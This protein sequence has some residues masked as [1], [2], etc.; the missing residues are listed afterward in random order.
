MKELL[1]F[2]MSRGIRVR[3]GLAVGFGE[4]ELEYARRTAG[5]VWA[6]AKGEGEFP[7]ESD[8]FDLVVLSVPAVSYTSVRE[9][10][11]VLVKG[12]NLVFSVPEKN[13]AQ[14]GLTPPEIY[15]VVREG[16]DIVELKKPGFWQLRR[17]GRVFKVCACKKA[18]REHHDFIREG[19]LP[20]TPFRSRT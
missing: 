12:G 7:Y 3:A 6:A 8:Q 14:E 16:F 19:S 11:R 5:G 13:G 1:E 4:E 20:F 18:W 9:A 17:L 15:K 2:F 10:N